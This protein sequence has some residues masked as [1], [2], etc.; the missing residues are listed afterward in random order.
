MPR[1]SV[2]FTPQQK[3][4]ISR[5]YNKIKPALKSAAKE[6][7][8]FLPIRKSDLKKLGENFDYR[9]KT[10]KGVFTKFPNPKLYKSKKFGLFVG[11][12]FGLRREIFFPFPLSVITMD[13]IRDYVDDLMRV[14][15]PDY[16]RWS[17][18]GYAGSAL[19]DPDIFGLYVDDLEGE[20]EDDGK[21]YIDAPFFNGVFLGWAPESELN[22]KSLR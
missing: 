22:G 14:H 4:A 17:V 3:A 8:G 11:T 20:L 2:D 21:K 12:N 5:V 19:Y 15:K 18:N 1:K 10:N 6:T 9:V 13:D 7:N 16:I